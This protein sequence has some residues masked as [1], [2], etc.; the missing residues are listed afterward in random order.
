MS[1]FFSSIWAVILPLIV[2]WLTGL[3]PSLGG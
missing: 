1:E 3:F 2:A